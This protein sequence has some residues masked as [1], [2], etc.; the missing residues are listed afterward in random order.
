MFLS[1]TH[2]LKIWRL[3]NLFSVC[4]PNWWGSTGHS[5]LLVWQAKFLLFGCHNSVIWNELNIQNSRNRN[6]DCSVCHNYQLLSE[7]HNWGHCIIGGQ[8]LIWLLKGRA[9]LRGKI[10]LR[11]FPRE[12][13]F[14]FLPAGGKCVF[15]GNGKSFESFFYV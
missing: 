7:F 5:R 14:H 10:F 15:T 1:Q 11:E 8:K 3:K 2:K 12:M 13:H 6:V 4:Q 9:G